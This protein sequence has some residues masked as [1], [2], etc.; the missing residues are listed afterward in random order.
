MSHSC[1]P[2]SLIPTA[3]GRLNHPRV[4]RACDNCRARKTRC[5]GG[6]PCTGCDIRNDICT[7]HIK[8]R[9]DRERVYI[10]HLERQRTLLISG[11]MKLYTMFQRNDGCVNQKLSRLH[12]PVH[13]HDLLGAL[14]VLDDHPGDHSNYHD[15]STSIPRSQALG[16]TVELH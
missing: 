8:R 3:R 9:W 6:Q 1:V 13:V 15:G 16:R 11:M 5:N 12:Q 2:R 10:E 14:G 7:Y 4:S